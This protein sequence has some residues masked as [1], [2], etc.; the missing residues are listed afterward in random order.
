MVR[1]VDDLK[2]QND[3]LKAALSRQAERARKAE[4]SLEAMR[5]ASQRKRLTNQLPD[6]VK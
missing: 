3:Q 5:K 2:T 6:A 4:K 1:R